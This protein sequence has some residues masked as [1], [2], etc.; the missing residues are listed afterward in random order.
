M[1]IAEINGIG[2][3]PLKDYDPACLYCVIEAHRDA[4]SNMVWAANATLDST[5]EYFNTLEPGVKVFVVTYYGSQQGVITFWPS[6]T[7]NHYTVGY[8]L[9][10]TYRG[11]GVMR[12]ALS[13]ALYT[14]GRRV[15]V[16]ATIRKKNLASRHVLRCNQFIL[17]TEESRDGEDWETLVRWTD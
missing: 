7:S 10:P 17:W 16:T 8:W 13:M 14:L 4:L 1:E 5:K 12:T 3:R 15:R 6:V 11:R 9:G 2:I